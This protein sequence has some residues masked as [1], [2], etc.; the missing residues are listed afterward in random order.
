MMTICR[1]FLIRNEC[2]YQRQLKAAKFTARLLETDKRNRVLYHLWQWCLL[3][4]DII[5][6]VKIYWRNDRLDLPDFV[7][8]SW[9]TPQGL[10]KGGS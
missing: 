10:L 2:L 1:S 7:S 8:F 5:A 4:F 9:A 3:W 6:F